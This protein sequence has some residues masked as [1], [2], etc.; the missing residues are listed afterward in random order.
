MRTIP[1][2]LNGPI[3]AAS[4][5]EAGAPGTPGAGQAAPAES[6][7]THFAQIDALRGVA[8]LMVVCHHCWVFGG[9]AGWPHV[10]LGARRVALFGGDCYG[11][12]GVDLFLVLSGFCLAW[13]FLADPGRRFSVRE[14]AGR[15]FW[16]I[17]PAYAATFVALLIAS[18]LCRRSGTEDVRRLALAHGP[19]LPQVAAGLGL[20]MTC[21]NASFW[22][23][24]LELRW[25]FVFPLVL[26]LARRRSAWYA[27]PF[28]LAA[29]ALTPPGAH[30]PL[31]LLTYLPAFALGVC[32][33]EVQAR[34]HVWLHG[35]LRR[36]ARPG[37]AA[38]L[39]LCLLVLPDAFSPRRVSLWEVVPA[40]LLFFF[41]VLAALQGRP[42]LPRPLRALQAV[43]LFSYSLYLIHQPLVE[44][45]GAVLHPGEWGPAAQVLFWHG[46]FLP[47][48]LFLSYAFYR[49]AEAPFCSR[50][51]RADLARRLF[52]DV[53]GRRA[54]GTFGTA[55]GAPDR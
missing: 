43:G 18:A 6:G 3:R 15:R 12:V 1:P 52:G 31:K 55:D 53:K 5:A 14:Y 2:Y 25:Y 17:Y 27:L 20:Q 26:L 54:G 40:G 10:T 39:L 28:A 33:A 8:A 36:G 44:V 46:A 11:Y 9:G 16:R 34:P 21:L 38:A 41:L 42:V 37:L 48:L 49:V 51:S 50:R 29:A 32:A 13:P 30:G 47:A 4:S 45:T 7:R 24:C 23:L 35:L 19:T 22:S